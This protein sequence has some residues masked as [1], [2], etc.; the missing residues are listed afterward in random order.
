MEHLN[1]IE[2]KGNV[3]NIKIY[4]TE[5]GQFARLSLAT[6][7]MFKGR[8]GNAV[9][10]TTWH[11]VIAWKNKGISTELNLIKKGSIVHVIGRIR[12]QKYT[13]NDNVERI[14]TEVVARSIEI[15]DTEET[16]NPAE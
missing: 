4:D 14:S 11:N 2:L 9:V 6:N 10:E 3:G 7:Y 13:G 5:N 12:Q 15:V 16:I 1:R 8:D